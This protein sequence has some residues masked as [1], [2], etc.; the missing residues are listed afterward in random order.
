MKKLVRNVVQRKKQSRQAGT[1]NLKPV[2][3]LKNEDC[4]G[5]LQRDHVVYGS[6]TQQELVQWLCRYHNCVEARE[7]R[8]F[9]AKEVLG[10][11]KL[12][13]PLRISL[14]EWHVRYGLHPKLKRR[15]HELSEEIPLPEKFLPG[16]GQQQADQASQV[17]SEERSVKLTLTPAFSNKKIVGFWVKQGRKRKLVQ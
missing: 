4:S 16:Q 5:V 2:C 10:G 17:I 14:N 13:G 11:I 1:E 15:I 7:L 9:V 6:V 12:A 3:V 8:L